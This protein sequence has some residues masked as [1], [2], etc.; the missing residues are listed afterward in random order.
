MGGVRLRRLI[1][2]LLHRGEFAM[3]Y[4][5]LIVVLLAAIGLFFFVKGKGG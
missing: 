2:R 4:G 1:P 3:Y 5:V